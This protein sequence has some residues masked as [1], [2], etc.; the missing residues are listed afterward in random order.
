MTAYGSKRVQEKQRGVEKRKR[1]RFIF[2]SAEGTNKT[3]TLYFKQFQSRGVQFKF[4]TGSST[5]PVKM[6]K[7]LVSKMNAE[8]FDVEYGDAAYCLVDGDNYPYK[9]QQ[10]AEADSLAREHAFKIILSNPCFEIWFICHDHFSTRQYTSGSEAVD[11]G[12]KFYPGYSKANIP[13]KEYLLEKLPAAIENAKKLRKWNE[14]QGKR[15]HTVEF[16]PSTEVYQIIEE[17]QLLQE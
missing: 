13:E 16:Q 1:T 15:N 4:V 8:G 10:I 6:S 14:D 7:D 5:D 12:K 9:N 11:E 3:E 2:I 17:A